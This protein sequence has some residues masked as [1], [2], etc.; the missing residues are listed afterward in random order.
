MVTT[1]NSVPTLVIWAAIATFSGLAAVLAWQW[2]GAS[3][4]WVAHTLVVQQQFSKLLIAAQDL[5]TGQ[6]GYFLTGDEA[7]LE[8]YTHAKAALPEIK[9]KL[10]ALVVDNGEQLDAVKEIEAT[11]DQRLARIDFG[12]AK[13]RAEGLAAAQ[14][15]LTSGEGKIIMDKLRALI[16]IAQAQEQKFFDQRERS[17]QTQRNWLLGSLLAMLLGSAGLAMFALVRERDRVAALEGTAASLSDM[18][19]SLEERV[20]ARTSDLAIERDRAEAER[21]RAEAILRDGTHRIGNTLA[22]VVGFIN[23]HIRHARDPLSIKT[24]TGARSR[25][26][27]IASAQRRMN[28]TNDLDLVRIDSLIESVMADLLAASGEEAVQVKVEIPPLLAPAQSA[29]SVCVLTQEFVMN[30][31]KHAFPEGRKGLITVTI[32]KTEGGGAVLTI[33]DDGVGMPPAADDGNGDTAQER[34]GNKI[35]TLLSRQFN[36]SIAYAPAKPGS[37]TPGA[38]VI[39]TLPDLKLAAAEAEIPIKPEFAVQA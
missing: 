17:Y 8:P 25:I 11:L 30:S 24:L 36:G 28:V 22:L 18:N 2:S 1:P 13:M 21:E 37:P 32:E 10:N 31:L 14:E 4:N 23:L 39:V 12:V 6:R 34:L 33:A 15:A 3:A 16:G 5:E 20:A 38:Q 26:H 19:K 29:T 27:A 35:A 7:Y 9:A